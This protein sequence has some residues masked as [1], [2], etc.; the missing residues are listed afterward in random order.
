MLIKS[1]GNIFHGELADSFTHPSLVSNNVDAELAA[2][3]IKGIPVLGRWDVNGA[4]GGYLVKDKLWFFSALRRRRNELG[5]EGCLQPDGSVCNTNLTQQF[6]TGK[7]TYQINRAHKFIGYYQWNRKDQLAGTNALIPWESRWNQILIGKVGKGEWQG[8]FGNRVIANAM[9]GYWDFN[10]KQYAYSDQPSAFDI[11]TL[12]SSGSSPAQ[13]FFGSTSSYQFSGPW[14]VS[15]GSGSVHWYLPSSVV[16]DHS[17]K[18]G[19]DH[20]RTW[21]IN[22]NGVHAASGDYILR[23]RNNVPY[24]INIYNLPQK[25]RGDDLYT[26]LYVKDQWRV[27]SRLT[28]NLG[29]HRARP[30]LHPGDEPRGEPDYRRRRTVRPVRRGVVPANRFPRLQHLRAP[31]ACGLRPDR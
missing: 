21:N 26:A 6:Y 14:A 11:V 31:C 20:Y 16:G 22:G 8:T 13:P 25:G 2:A 19:L 29:A 5:V 12:R 10:S 27:G 30:P 7:L 15:Q 28:L 18:F 3:G 9:W 1:G 24:Q 23:F 4:L 17:L